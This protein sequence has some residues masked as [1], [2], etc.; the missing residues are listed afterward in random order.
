M[1]NILL[2]ISVFLN[3]SLIVIF[4]FYIQKSMHLENDLAIKNQIIYDLE[5]KLENANFE[6]TRKEIVIVKEKSK[7]NLGV[8]YFTERTTKK[9]VFWDTYIIKYKFQIMLNGIPIGHPALIKEESYTEV[10]KE[11]INKMI[12]QIA[13][14]LLQHGAGAFVKMV[15][16]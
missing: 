4:L 10:D 12:D 13:Q 11:Q 6:I 14:P 8:K 15:K 9:V 2:I 1:I 5:R 3:F 7:I 16:L